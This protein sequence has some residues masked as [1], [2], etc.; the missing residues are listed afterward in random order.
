MNFMIHDPINADEHCKVGFGA[1]WR[2]LN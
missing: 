1:L 2:I